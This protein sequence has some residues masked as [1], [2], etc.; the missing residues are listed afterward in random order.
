MGGETMRHIMFFLLLGLMLAACSQEYEIVDTAPNEPSEKATAESIEIKGSDTLLQLVSNM[1]EA[2]SAGN[3]VRISVTGGGSGTGIAALINGEID[4]A[5]ASR[6][7]KEKEIIMAGER[8]TNPWE[9]VIA[10]DML[11]VIVHE[12]NTVRQLTFDEIGQ[13]FRGEIVNWEE[14]GGDD[15]EITLYGRQSTSGTYAFFMEHVLEA[16]YSPEMRNMEGNQAILDAVRQDDSGI[17]YAG[18]GYIV[19]ESGNQA[20][21]INVVEVGD[22]DGEYIS[23]LDKDKMPDYP[24]SRELYQYLAEKPEENSAVYNFLLFELSDQGQSIVEDTGF[25]R[26]TA[27]DI[28]YNNEQLAKI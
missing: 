4:I 25:V 11:S 2:Y 13:I 21:G 18:L 12:D 15:Q 19:D 8:G 17:G 14:V 9:F 16:D 10:R 5:D 1:A 28:Q 6:K 23:P 7:I 27:K 22:G 20:D 26:L 3:Q 24:I